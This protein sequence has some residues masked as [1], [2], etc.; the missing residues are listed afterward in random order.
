MYG[1]AEHARLKRL[2]DAL[3]LETDPGKRSAIRREI[4]LAEATVRLGMP[5]RDVSD[6]PD[7]ASPV[8]APLRPAGA[9]DEPESE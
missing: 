4:A 8:N 2:K 3:S 1:Q 9:P 7:G 6:S 5:A